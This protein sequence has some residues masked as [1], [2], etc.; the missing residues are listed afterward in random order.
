M[1]G[2]F[3]GIPLGRY[4]DIYVAIIYPEKRLELN[5]PHARFAARMLG[6][7]TSLALCDPAKNP[8]S[9]ESRIKNLQQHRASSPSGQAF[10]SPA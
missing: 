5:T 3:T 10:S 4:F 2:I 6:R 1:D 9:R 8:P 7:V